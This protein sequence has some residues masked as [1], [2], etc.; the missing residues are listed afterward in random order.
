MSINVRDC[1]HYLTFRALIVK[2]ISEE[3]DGTINPKTKYRTFLEH[4]FIEANTWE[5]TNKE[6][7]GVEY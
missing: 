1:G 3:D 6:I 7:Q 5:L 4:K 2:H